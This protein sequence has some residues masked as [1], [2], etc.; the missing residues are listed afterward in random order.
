MANILLNQQEQ[1]TV[2]FPCYN[3]I[4][5]KLQHEKLLI[6]LH[7]SIDH[8]M[9][10]IKKRGRRMENTVSREFLKTR[11]SALLDNISKFNYNQLIMINIDDIDIMDEIYLNQL[12]K[13]IKEHN[14]IH[15]Y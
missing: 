2:F 10:R 5:S 11:Q 14:N 6:L 7:G 12:S 8:I 1:T 15:K 3:Y 9:E 4:Y 13:F